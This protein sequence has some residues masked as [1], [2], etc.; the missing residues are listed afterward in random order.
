[1]TGKKVEREKAFLLLPGSVCR[2]FP[3]V[4]VVILDGSFHVKSTRK[5]DTR[6]RF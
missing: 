2:R 5:M 6:H 1:M 4:T 3:G